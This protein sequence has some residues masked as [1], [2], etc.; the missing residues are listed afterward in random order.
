MYTIWLG[1]MYFIFAY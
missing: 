1:I